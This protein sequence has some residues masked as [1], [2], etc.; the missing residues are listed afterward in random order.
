[1][2]QL[3]VRHSVTDAGN[4]GARNRCHVSR[5][6]CC[7][8]VIQRVLS[9][10]I[11]SNSSS[12]KLRINYLFKIRIIQIVIS[13]M[14]FQYIFNIRQYFVSSH[15]QKQIDIH[16]LQYLQS[17]PYPSLHEIFVTVWIRASLHIFTT[18]SWLVLSLY[19]SFACHQI[20]FQSYLNSSSQINCKV[21]FCTAPVS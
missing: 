6:Q 8:C 13:E 4:V 18:N 2:N 9:A 17:I 10:N 19:S 20:R 1:M 12:L 7:Q 3:R 5:N 11:Q 14:Y 15:F 16:T 21:F